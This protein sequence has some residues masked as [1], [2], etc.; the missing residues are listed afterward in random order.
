MDY[1]L[2][3]RELEESLNSSYSGYL[4]KDNSSTRDSLFMSIRNL[5]VGIATVE[6]APKKYNMELDEIGNEYAL[7]L[8]E[9]IVVSGFRFHTETGRVPFTQYVRLNLKDVLI[10]DFR[11][12]HL[13]LHPDME[14]LCDQVS[15]GRVDTNPDRFSKS[16]VA[17]KIYRGLLLFYKKNEVKKYLNLALDVVYRNK[18]QP[19]PHDKLPRDLRDFTIVLISVAKRMAYESEI[20]YMDGHTDVKKAMASSIR[21]S[22][23]I[24]SVTQAEAFPRELLL[25]LDLESLYRLCTVSG[26]RKIKVPTLRQ[27]D[28]IVGAIGGVSDYIMEGKPYQ[29]T[30]KKSKTDLDLVFSSKT[31]MHHFISKAIETFDLKDGEVSQE[32]LIKVLSTSKKAIEGYVKEI[33]KEKKSYRYKSEL[34]K[35]IREQKEFLASLE[36]QLEELPQ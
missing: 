20:S 19:I 25:S 35:T 13:Q 24:A 31:N 34:L 18:H 33:S 23:F 2:N 15:M 22:V 17:E 11:N 27:L 30:L 29:E 1:G 4:K 10:S 16:Y 26:G 7:R 8:F 9:R 14:V 5:A 28:T 6:K 21:S 12:N 36:A 3:L 32:P